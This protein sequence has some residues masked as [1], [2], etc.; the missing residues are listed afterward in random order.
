MSRK[1]ADIEQ[2][3][4]DFYAALDVEALARHQRVEPLDFAKAR[5]MGK[6]WPRDESV[7]DFIAA[8]RKWRDEEGDEFDR[9]QS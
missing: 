8:V 3:Y 5:R 6:F 4:D 9:E 1:E 2:S 7:D